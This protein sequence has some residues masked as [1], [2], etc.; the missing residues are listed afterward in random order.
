M[1]GL[2][3]STNADSVKNGIMYF[4]VSWEKYFTTDY[5]MK[6]V[7]KI[8]NVWAYYVSAGIVLLA[9]IALLAGIVRK[10]TKG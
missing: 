10:R 8:K 6:A 7:S 5:E 3:T 2:L 4:G 9:L 1:P